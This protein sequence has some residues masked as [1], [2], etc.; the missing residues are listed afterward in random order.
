MRL[1]W[2]TESADVAWR[3]AQ[4]RAP[5]RARGGIQA[6]FSPLKHNQE[7]FGILKRRHEHTERAS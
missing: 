7:L 5:N 6:Q 4:A 3:S 1:M 2:P